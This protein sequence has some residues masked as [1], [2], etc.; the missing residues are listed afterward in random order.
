MY[1]QIDTIVPA[2]WSQI[3]EVCGA[4][5]IHQNQLTW[6]KQVQHKN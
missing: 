5:F 6:H 1:P 4:A 2:F 3:C